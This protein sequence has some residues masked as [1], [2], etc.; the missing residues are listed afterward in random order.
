MGREIVKSSAGATPSYRFL[1]SVIVVPIIKL[2]WHAKITGSQNIPPTGGIVLAGNHIAAMDAV[3]L[4]GMINRPVAYP[5]KPELFLGER[6]LGSRIV[7]WL[8]HHTG[9]IALDRSGGAA[10]TAAFAPLQKRLNDGGVIG[11][12][13][14]GTRSPDGRMYR[15]K[16]GVARIALAA[17]VPIVPVAAFHTKEFKSRVGIPWVANPRIVVGKPLHFPQYAGRVNDYQVLRWVTDSV[18]RAVQE[19]S[20]QEFVDVYASQVKYSAVSAAEVEAAKKPYP[21]FGTV[22]P[23]EN[24]KEPDGEIQTSDMES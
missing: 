21:G 20:E 14:E 9:Q 7:A 17:N 18:M 8:A 6:G 24:P 2:L 22:A 12:Y 16:T 19:L 1:K 11:I 4:A 23:P 10:S 13:P 5:G 15:G 3:V